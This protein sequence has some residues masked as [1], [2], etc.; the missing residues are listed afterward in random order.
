M[1]KP[2]DPN[3]AAAEHLTE[4]HDT[5]RHLRERVQDLEQRSRIDE[6]IRQLEAALNLLAVKTGALL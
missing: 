6:A 2:S 1:D 5:L 4:A 3:A